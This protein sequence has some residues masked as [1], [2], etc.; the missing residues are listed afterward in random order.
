[1]NPK[2]MWNT[3]QKEIPENNL[4]YARSCIRQ[5]FFPASEFIFLD[6]MRNVL[7]KY[8]FDDPNH[9]TCTGIGYHADVVPFDTTQTVIARQFSLMTEA[10]LE[11]IAVSCVTSFG[12]YTEVLEMW[13]HHPEQ[14]ERIR[15]FLYK[16]TKREFNIPKSIAHT[17]DI[18]YS[19]KGFIAEKSKY[20]LINKDTGEPLRAVE[21]IGCHYAKM[22]PSNVVGGAEFPRVLAGMIESWGGQVIDYPE[23]RHCCGFGFR[24]YLVQAN[25]GYSVSNSQKKFES[26]KPYKPD[27]ILTNCPG[28]A[29]F[30]DKWQYLIA[31]MEGETYDSEGKG[32]P[33]LTYEELAGLVLGYNPWD[34][35]LQIHQVQCEGLLDKIGIEYN[36]D[37]KYADKDGNPLPLPKKPDIL[38]Q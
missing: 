34:L 19:C 36:P 29:M 2:K 1:M 4:Y 37:L 26:M 8:V 24:N 10:G 32:I 22:F 38:I 13:R 31:E 35:G 21:H 12:L 28:C 9:T 23:R 6:I 17:S 16:A 3:Y 15:K 11:N 18:M 25:R 20:S 5:N 33:V 30:M 14:L 27:F 7:G